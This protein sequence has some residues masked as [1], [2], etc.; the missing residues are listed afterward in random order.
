MTRGSNTPVCN[1]FVTELIT[2][3]ARL[4]HV[5]RSGNLISHYLEAELLRENVI[6]V[7][8]YRQ[9]EMRYNY[10][11]LA[12]IFDTNPKHVLGIHINSSTCYS[13]VPT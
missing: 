6:C 2:F 4:G 5:P 12:F 9:R 3:V 8:Q 7:I 13:F 10:P 11:S 1:Y